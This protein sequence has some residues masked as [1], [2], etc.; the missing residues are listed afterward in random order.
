MELGHSRGNVLLQLPIIV[1]RT[2]EAEPYFEWYAKTA[3]KSQLGQ[4]KHRFLTPVTAI[5]CN[6]RAV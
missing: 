3:I 2:S 4:D 6:H 5:Y 1:L